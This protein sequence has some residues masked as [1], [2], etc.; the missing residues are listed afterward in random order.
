MSAEPVH[1]EA[2]EDLLDG[3]VG[4]VE[5]LRGGGGDPLWVCGVFQGGPT[6]NIRLN[7][8]I[9]SV[10]DRAARVLA[11]RVGLEV[12]ATAPRWYMAVDGAW[13][14]DSGPFDAYFVDDE[15]EDCTQVLGISTVRDPAEAMRLALEATR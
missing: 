12:G 7:L 2:T 10:M 3:W 15:E 5:Y 8:R 14:L 11:A 9:P 1:I 13:V 4:P 6:A